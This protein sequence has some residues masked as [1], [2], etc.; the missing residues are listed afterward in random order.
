MS[1]L[2]KDLTAASTIPMV[3][4]ILSKEDSYG[5]K[6]IKTV[7]SG[8]QNRIHWNEGTLYPV[9]RKME[10]K[11]LIRS[12]WRTFDNRKRRY[13]SITDQGKEVLAIE[14]D[15]WKMM[16]ATLTRLWN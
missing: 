5:Y 2:S 4:A 6:I 11:E 14:M 3:L 12:Y 9:L 8:S 1:G 15:N 7:R 13:Y 16:L 10:E